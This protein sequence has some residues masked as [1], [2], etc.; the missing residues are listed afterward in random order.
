MAPTVVIAESTTGAA[1]TDTNIKR[2][3]KA[4]DIDRAISERTGW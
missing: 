4:C 2:L 1:R 3:L